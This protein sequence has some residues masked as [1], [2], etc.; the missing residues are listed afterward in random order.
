MSKSEL[1][2]IIQIH[3][4]NI[5]WDFQTKS[6]HEKNWWRLRKRIFDKNLRLASHR[7][8]APGNHT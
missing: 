5:L 4:W 6:Y 3:C 2:R 7:A 8:L 1:S